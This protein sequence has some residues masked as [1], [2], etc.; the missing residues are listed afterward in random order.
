MH[1]V[2]IRKHKVDDYVRQT[3]NALRGNDF[4]FTKRSAWPD[5]I[6]FRCGDGVMQPMHVEP[7]NP[8]LAWILWVLGFTFIS[9]LFILN[10]LTDTKS[11]F[12]TTTKRLI[13]T[14]SISFRFLGEKNN[15]HSRNRQ[16]FIYD[17]IERKY[18]KC[19][20]NNYVVQ[21]QQQQRLQIGLFDLN[22]TRNGV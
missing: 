16:H 21:S 6:R 17:E 7:S 19:N 9:E 1:Y 12:R 4:K 8:V 20:Q 2:C 11:A 14:N 13:R 10:E 5:C 22:Y 15:E 3:H 18:R